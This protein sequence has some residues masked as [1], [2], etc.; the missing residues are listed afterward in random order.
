MAV[1]VSTGIQELDPVDVDKIP[2]VFGTRVFVV[3]RLRALPA[4][5]INAGAFVK[6]FAGDLCQAIEGFHGKPFR[7]FLRY[8][9]FVLPSF[10]RGDG[11]LRYGR[12]LL[13]VF[14]IRIT[15]EISDQ[16]YFLHLLLLLL[17]SVWP[18]RTPTCTSAR[19]AAVAGSAT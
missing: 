15:A 9:V 4:L 10:R 8:A 2:V 13:A 5:H 17:L 3:P 18:L 7:M 19:S 14:H 6:V 11:K 12:S 16:H 1:P